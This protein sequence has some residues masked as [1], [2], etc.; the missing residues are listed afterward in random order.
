MP[1]RLATTLRS[2]T[3]VAIT[4]YTSEVSHSDLMKMIRHIVNKMQTNRRLNLDLSI[5][6]LV[7]RCLA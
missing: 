3:D 2:M 6:L 7:L 5:T 1:G 4:Q